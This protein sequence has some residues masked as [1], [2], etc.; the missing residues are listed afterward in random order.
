MNILSKLS[1]RASKGS[2]WLVHFSSIPSN[3]PNIVTINV[4]CST[5]LSQS[6]FS[7]K[8]SNF[9][10]KTLTKRSTNTIM[11]ISSLMI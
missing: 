5:D 8:I 4:G 9:P 11:S 10:S 6:Y 7:L 2:I 1:F 3:I